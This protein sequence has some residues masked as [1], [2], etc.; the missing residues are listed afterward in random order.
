ML[1]LPH[2]R[3][4]MHRHQDQHPFLDRYRIR[5]LRFHFL[6]DKLICHSRV[7]LPL[8]SGQGL[9]RLLQFSGVLA[10]ESK[11]VVVTDL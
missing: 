11:T 9:M 10:S 2:R 3:Q 5:M 6:D 4:V 8:G 7:P 1:R